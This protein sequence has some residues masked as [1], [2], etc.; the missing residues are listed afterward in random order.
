[1]SKI[2]SFKL[3]LLSKYRNVL[4]GIGILD[5]LIWHFAGA[6]HL[7]GISAQVFGTITRSVFTPG[8]LFLSGFGIYYSYSAN[9]NKIDFFKRRLGRLLIPFWVMVTIIFLFRLAVSG[10]GDLSYYLGM[11][12][13]A[14]F[15]LPGKTFNYW[16]I[17]VV[18]A[19]YIV[20]PFIHDFVFGKNNNNGRG[21]IYLKTSLICVSL[22]ILNIVLGEYYPY[23]DELE[24]AIPKLPMLFIGMIAGYLAKV[25]DTEINI[26]SWS[27]LIG[28]TVII[29]YLLKKDNKYFDQYYYI[30]DKLLTIPLL[31][32]IFEFLVSRNNALIKR[33]LSVFTWLGAFTLELYVIHIYLMRVVGDFPQLPEYAEW[34]I[35]VPV[36]FLICIPMKKL[37]TYVTNLIIRK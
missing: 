35:A 2:K 15:W 26:I 5:V 17:A 37:S 1:M 13:T 32:I 25:E 6:Y 3:S 11:I 14:S 22:V 31:I 20:Y 7:E 4:M 34:W 8:F 12:T 29:C 28:T 10:V 19:F 21:E 23:Y 27:L 30:I 16:Y 33:L 24:L 9:S 36:S 18:I